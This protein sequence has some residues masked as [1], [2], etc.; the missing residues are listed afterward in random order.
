MYLGLVSN[1]SL[2]NEA[3][4]LSL[5]E[6]LHLLVSMAWAL[7]IG[8]HNICLYTL[9]LKLIKFILLA[10]AVPLPFKHSFLHIFTI[11]LLLI[12]ID[13][14]NLTVH[15]CNCILIGNT[16]V[17]KCYSLQWVRYG[18]INI[19]LIALRQDASKRSIYKLDKSHK[20]DT[21]DIQFYINFI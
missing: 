18:R 4:C 1:K 19:L 10:N 12:E 8:E 11:S 6:S 2:M 13:F 15:I 21:Y 20:R 16:C 3:V 7:F 14:K 17:I 9:Y 5:S